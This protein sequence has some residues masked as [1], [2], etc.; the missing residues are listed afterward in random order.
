MPDTPPPKP[1]TALALYEHYAAHSAYF[2]AFQPGAL[3]QIT[4]EGELRRRRLFVPRNMVND[5]FQL[6]PTL[7]FLTLDLRGDP[8]SGYGNGDPSLWSFA[9]HRRK[10][11]LLYRRCTPGM[12]SRPLPSLPVRLDVVAPPDGEPTSETPS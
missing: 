8:S 1:T 11:W 10:S 3:V 5:Y 12:P 6:D 7:G 2:D 9:H 4:F